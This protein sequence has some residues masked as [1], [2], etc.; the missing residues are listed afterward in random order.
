MNSGPFFTNKTTKKKKML[1]FIKILKIEEKIGYGVPSD[2]FVSG[3]RNA[4]PCQIEPARRRLTRRTPPRTSV[5]IQT[6]FIMYP[7]QA[8]LP[9]GRKCEK[10]HSAAGEKRAKTKTKIIFYNDHY[11]FFGFG[12]EFFSVSAKVCDSRNW[13]SRSNSSFERR[14]LGAAQTSLALPYPFRT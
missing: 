14:L 11:F 10:E 5:E 6:C 7:W 12:H 2:L 8:S 1:N 3:R 4:I 13:N 9:R